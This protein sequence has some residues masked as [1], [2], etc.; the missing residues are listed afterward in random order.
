MREF[1]NRVTSHFTIFVEFAR[2]DFDILDQKG[3]VGLVYV[4][5]DDPLSIT[6][7]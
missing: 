7:D 4:V 3:L 6:H 5:D 2:M 1:G